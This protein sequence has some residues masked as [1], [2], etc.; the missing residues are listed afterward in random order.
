MRL[1]TTIRA[2]LMAACIVPAAHAQG[3]A[4]SPGQG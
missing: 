4:T 2:A 1:L 3:A